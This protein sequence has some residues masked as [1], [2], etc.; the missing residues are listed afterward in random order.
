MNELRL[1]FTK[2]ADGAYTVRLDHTWGGN[3]S[4]NP[5]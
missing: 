2:A 5:G 3:A 1:L 4:A